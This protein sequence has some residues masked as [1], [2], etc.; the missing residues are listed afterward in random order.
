M[1][2]ASRSSTTTT[3]CCVTSPASSGL[4]PLND[5]DAI[6]VDMDGDG[7]LDIV[8][9]SQNLL[10]VDLRRGDGYVTG[11]TYHLTAGWG[12]AAGDVDGDGRPDLYVQQGV[13]DVQAPDMLLLND[14]NG[15]ELTPFPIPQTAAGSAD[16]VIP[17]DYDRNGLDDFVVLNGNHKAGPVQLIAFFPKGAV[18]RPGPGASPSPA[19]APWSE[20]AGSPVATADPAVSS[21][22]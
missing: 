21:A 5:S 3:A 13:G 22:P 7:K 16:A 4:P 12:V 20:P 9:V 19:R 2:S 6:A 15:T 10:R 17:I 14:A 11:A 1:A 18:P 8:E